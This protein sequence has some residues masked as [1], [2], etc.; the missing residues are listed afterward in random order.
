MHALDNFIS[1]IPDFD[2]DIPILAIP[3]SRRP[4][5]DE[6]VSD[7]LSVLVPVT[8]RLGLGSGKRPLIQLL[9][10]RL[11]KSW[12]DLLVDSKSMNPLPKLLIR[13]HRRVLDRGS[14]FIAQKGMLIMNIFCP[15]L[16]CNS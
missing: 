6:F 10:K 8:Q 11:R 2:G 14:Q 5:S 12:G 9:R 3:V 1:P 4:P 7:P 16:V 15:C 13:L